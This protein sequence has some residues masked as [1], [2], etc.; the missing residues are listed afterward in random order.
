MKHLICLLLVLLV[1]TVFA[2]CKEETSPKIT[3]INVS[4]DCGVVPLRIEV[5][6][7]ASGGDESGDPTGGVNN[8]DYVWDFGDGTGATSISYHEYTTPSPPDSFYVITLTVTDPDGKTDK[9]Q[10]E[11][12]A[13]ADSLHIEATMTPDTGITTATPVMFDYTAKTCGV[14]PDFDQDYVKLSPAWHVMDPAFPDGEVVYYGRTPTHT[15]AAPGTYDVRLNVFYAEW[16]VYRNV[17]LQ[18]TVTGP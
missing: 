6:G 14:D 8:L 16:S 4:Q 1:A 7:T 5:Y 13:I 10:A 12:V 15:F 2:G 9:S 17:D 11:V 3:R 18:V